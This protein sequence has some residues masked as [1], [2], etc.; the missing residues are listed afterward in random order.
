MKKPKIAIF[1]FTDCE[2][3]E[4]QIIALK[5][6][7]IDLTEKVEIVSWRLAQESIRTDYE[8]AIIEGTPLTLS[9]IEH[10]KEIRKQAKILIALGA[11][12][13]LGGVNALAEPNRQALV[14]KIYGTNYQLN[15]QNA[16]PLSHYVKIDSVIPGCPVDPNE[17]ERCLSELLL[18]IIPKPQPFAVCSQCRAAQVPC[19]LLEGEACLGP[20]TVGGCDAVC[21]KHGLACTG[22]FGLLEGQNVKALACIIGEERMRKQAN[23]FLKNISVGEEQEAKENKR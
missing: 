20:I 16:L 6:K 10:L 19:L 12:A 7:I 21:T 15:V 3:C 4:L 18:G 22:C 11:C 23:I 9:E 14:E 2:G 17:L 8:I 5:E 13:H 1:D